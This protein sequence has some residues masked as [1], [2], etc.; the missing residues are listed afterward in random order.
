MRLLRLWQQLIRFKLARQVRVVERF[1]SDDAVEY[2]VHVVRRVA[3]VSLDAL[4]ALVRSC[5]ALTAGW[6][7]RLLPGALASH[8]RALFLMLS[9]SVVRVFVDKLVVA[10]VQLL[11]F[12]NEHVTHAKRAQLKLGRNLAPLKNRQLLAHRYMLYNELCQ[13]VRAYCG[14]YKNN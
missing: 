13:V 1:K 8:D 14:H 7:C 12:L 11:S 9:S 10:R 6:L 4:E 2:E 5:L 3:H